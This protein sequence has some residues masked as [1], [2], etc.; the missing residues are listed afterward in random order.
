MIRALIL[1]TLL[2]ACGSPAHA[3]PILLDGFEGED[4]ASGTAKDC[5]GWSDTGTDSTIALITQGGGDHTHNATNGGD[6]SSQRAYKLAPATGVAAYLRRATNIGSYARLAVGAALHL[7]TAPSSGNVRGALGL[8][9]A[10]ATLG[11]NARLNSSSTLDLYYANTLLGTGATVLYEKSCTTQV[12]QGCSGSGCPTGDSCAASCASGGTGCFHPTVEVSEDNQTAESAACELWVGGHRDVTATVSVVTQPIVNVQFGASDTATGTYTAWID[13]VVLDPSGRTGPGYLV[14]SVPASDG[15]TLQ[16]GVNSCTAHYG[17]TND[18][19]TGSYTFDSSSQV[20]SQK[21]QSDDIASFTPAPSWTCAGCTVTGVDFVFYGATASGGSSYVPRVIPMS[22]PTPS[23][24]TLGTTSPTFSLSANTTNRELFRY[25]APRGATSAWGKTSLAQMGLRLVMGAADAFTQ[26]RALIAYTHIRRPDAP[27]P[28]TLADHN[29]GSEDGKIVLYG[30]GDS[31]T[32]Y[33]TTLASVCSGGSGSGTTICSQEDYC[34]WATTGDKPQGGCLGS[35]AAEKN[36]GCQ[37]CANRRG[38]FNSGAGYACGPNNQNDNNQVPSKPT[39]DLCGANDGATTAGCCTTMGC[40][41]GLTNCCDGDKSVSCST[42]S[43]C[44]LGNCSTCSNVDCTSQTPADTCVDACPDTATSVGTCPVGR[45]T[46]VEWLSETTGA[47]VIAAC[48][49]GGETSTAAAANFSSV[50]DGAY[51][52]CQLVRGSGQCLCASSADCDGGTCSGNRCTSGAKSSCTAATECGPTYFICATAPPDII[53]DMHGFND[54][55][56]AT[57]SAPT[58]TGPYA[59]ISSLSDSGKLCHPASRTLCLKKSDCSG[60]AADADCWGFRTGAGY[61]DRYC[62]AE[63]VSGFEPW[64]RGNCTS[65]LP[66]CNT[67]AECPLAGMTCFSP[68]GTAALNQPTWAR[69]EGFCGCTADAQC[70]A[71]YK[72]AGFAASISECATDGSLTCLCRKSCTDDA[73]CGGVTGACANRGDGTLVCKGACDAPSDSQTCSTDADCARSLQDLILATYPNVQRDWTG[74][75]TGGKCHCTGPPLCAGACQRGKCQQTLTTCSTDADC[76]DAPV[77]GRQH[78]QAYS[79]YG[80]TYALGQYQLMQQTIDNLGESTPPLLYISTLPD[81]KT[82]TCGLARPDGPGYISGLATHVTHTMRSVDPRRAFA[83][84]SRAATH[85]DDV[86]LDAFGGSLV[87]DAISEQVNAVRTCAHGMCLGPGETE[88]LSC[89]ATA[90]C[91][92]GRTC[93]FGSWAS[94]QR[95]CRNND[96]TWPTSGCVEDP[97]ACACTDGSGC[98][99]TQ[100]C[101]LRPCTC[102]CRT[103]AECINWFGSGTKC[104]SGA[105]VTTASCGSGTSACQTAYGAGFAC[106]SGVCKNGAADA[107][108]AG[109]DACNAE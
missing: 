32:S 71:G 91:A 34:D 43:Q 30:I 14:R 109:G 84:A 104:C 73:G 105:C 97:T 11:C 16:W 106:T 51:W 96:G 58:C 65:W 48:G 13:D 17:C 46:W 99:V 6:A 31:V 82:A 90:D 9:L 61:T 79:S 101:A 62:G 33:E 87:G 54:I 7:G 86:H 55:L 93:T 107:C 88:G 57:L 53:I 67:S 36:A 25:F 85:T 100:S 83:R 59:S 45:T 3:T 76:L 52:G 44:L 81:L 78:A 38:E 1:I 70:L 28:I 4:G 103:D 89:G 80:H 41:G 20:K 74:V 102:D 27:L 2:L 15:T 10:D 56:F 63:G 98:S 22:C 35:S 94:P 50:L 39:C 26:I 21:A 23:T 29:K 18:Y 49:H 19:G 12:L 40:L 42:D 72:C 47:D 37:T 95:Y 108:P 8:V 69:Q 75:C 68:D 5:F 60:V 92:G 24:C 66:L 77:C 64:I